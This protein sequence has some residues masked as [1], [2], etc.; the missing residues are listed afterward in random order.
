MHFKVVWSEIARNDLREII[1]YIS[2]DNRDIAFE[3]LENIRN[4]AS[5]LSSFPERCRIVPELKKYKI[6]TYR[7]VIYKVWRIIY[8]IE[9]KSVYIGAVFDARRNLED[10]LLDRILMKL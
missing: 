3:V 2:N 4:K 5:K 9:Q 1:R 6:L 8:K 10:I 7:E